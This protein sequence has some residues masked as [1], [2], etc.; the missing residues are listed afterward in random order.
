MLLEK[1]RKEIVEY[2]KKMFKSGL[3]EGT[4]GNLSIYD[5][6]SGCMVISPSGINYEDI[7]PEDVVVMGLDGTI[8]EGTKKPSS[9]HDLHSIIYQTKPEI[10]A[11]VHTHSKFCVVLSCMNIP[12]RAVHYVLADAGGFEIPVAPYR[13]YGTRE[14]AEV[15][16]DTI[17]ENQAVLM[18]NHG[19]LG[20]GTSLKSAY[21]VAATCEWVAEIQWRCLAIGQP[22]VLSDEQMNVVLEKFREYGQE[23][24]DKDVQSY[25]G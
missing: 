8:V 19:M 3:T 2:G 5:A 16:K 21:G 6:Q 10:K 9:E 14:L 13:T 1:E 24:D 22:C 7:K 4:G 15:V 25:F 23:R 20:C 17:G 18:A 11:V 12:L